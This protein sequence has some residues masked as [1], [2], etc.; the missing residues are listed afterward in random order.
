M[1]DWYPILVRFF[2]PAGIRG[3]KLWTSIVIHRCLT[4]S[5][6][7]RS[8]DVHHWNDCLVPTND[9]K[10]WCYR[11]V[12]PPGPD[13]L[14]GKPE[15]PSK[16]PERYFWEAKP[17]LPFW[18]HLLWFWGKKIVG[19]CFDVCWDDFTL[20]SGHRTQLTPL[21]RTERKWLKLLTAGKN[22]LVIS[23]AD[24]CRY[25]VDLKISKAWILKSDPFETISDISETC[26]ELS[27]G[28]SLALMRKRPLA[29]RNQK[30]STNRCLSCDVQ[31]TTTKM[32]S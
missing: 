23:G 4:H 18:K 19:V 21:G 11:K 17:P 1:C 7:Q 22:I 26:S 12:T 27:H 6:G 28:A 16:T 10:P 32:Y 24:M 25:F 8:A 14:V 2:E 5:Y 31:P 15:G 30:V 29:K 3:L 9:Y 13:R 20:C